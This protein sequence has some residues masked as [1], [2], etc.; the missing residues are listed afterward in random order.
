MKIDLA[1]ATA[2]VRDWI[3][4]NRVMNLYYHMFE[5]EQAKR[6]GYEDKWLIV[7]SLQEDFGK[8]KWYV[9]EISFEGI[10]LKIGIG[11][12]EGNT[13]KLEEHKIEWIGIESTVPT[14]GKGN[15]INK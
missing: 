13:I 12:L 5:V 15:E 9:F 6:I 1:K 7:C 4:E 11:H 8:R 10:I 3:R 2:I 14:G